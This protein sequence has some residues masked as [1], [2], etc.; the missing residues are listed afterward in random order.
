MDNHQNCQI[1]G[2][3]QGTVELANTMLKETTHLNN[4]PLSKDQK[5]ELDCQTYLVKTKISELNYE[6]ENLLS[7]ATTLETASDLTPEE[8]QVRKKR[9]EDQNTFDN[10]SKLILS[11]YAARI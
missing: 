11:L 1:P 10:I 2:F 9:L 7:L 5:L 8:R 4:T 3:L 6:L